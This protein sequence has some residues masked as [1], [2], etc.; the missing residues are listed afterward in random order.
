MRSTVVLMLTFICCSLLFA[1]SPSS[2]FIQAEQDANHHPKLHPIDGD[3]DG[4]NTVYLDLGAAALQVVSTHFRCQKPLSA[5][6]SVTGRQ[7]KTTGSSGCDFTYFRVTDA[8]VNVHCGSSSSAVTTLEREPSSS[9]VQVDQAAEQEAETTN[10][11]GKQQGCRVTVQLEL[12]L[13]PDLPLL[14]EYQY[15]EMSRNCSYS[16]RDGN[17]TATA[18]AASLLEEDQDIWRYSI[19][20]SHTGASDKGE[21]HYKGYDHNGYSMCCDFIPSPSAALDSS[22]SSSYCF[23]QPASGDVHRYARRVLLPD[24]CPLPQTPDVAAERARIIPS[25]ASS[26]TKKAALGTTQNPFPR[27]FGQVTKPLPALLPGEWRAKVQLWRTRYGAWDRRNKV[28]QESWLPTPAAAPAVGERKEV[29]PSRFME[30]EQ[31]VEMLGRV[32]ISFRL[33][34]K[35]TT[36]EKMEGDQQERQ[37]TGDE[38][39]QELL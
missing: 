31:N 33:E 27:V 7:Q 21:I 37:G 22:S 10:G 2:F 1:S 18:A 15:M 13:S 4:R 30:D 9:G 14:L 17:T 12:Q 29:F 8:S 23:W 26:S 3:R 5:F 34:E 32:V 6:N 20:L 38:H 39:Q 11:G 36:T 16:S 19:A 25:V 35:T 28:H 24:I